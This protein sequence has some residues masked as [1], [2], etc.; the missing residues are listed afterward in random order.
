MANTNLDLNTVELVST[1]RAAPL[2][3]SPS[4]GDYNDS[5]TES[6]ADL[7]SL[8]GFINDI[9]IP[10]YN[11][12]ASNIQPSSIS[13]PLGLEGRF[14]YGDTTDTTPLF[15]DSLN[16]TSLTIP[17]SIRVVNGIVTTIQTIVT[18]LNVQV[19][20]IQTQLSSTN[21]NDIAQAL[22]NFAASLQILTA[23]TTG[24]TL[25]ISTVLANQGKTQNFRTV[26]TVITSGT[27]TE[28]V[29]SL[30]WPVSFVDN[31]YTVEIS[32][33]FTDSNTVTV[34]TTLH[35]YFIKQASG[36]GLNIHLLL[37][38]S[39]HAHTVVVHGK[40]THD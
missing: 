31:N 10:I 11:G 15:F 24:N 17:D 21:Q 4:S 12:L 33:E 16:N 28:T 19:T 23:Q 32:L 26:G 8:S 3:G 37:N 39:T 2:N 18:T 20:S 6:L 5:W 38:D 36:T 22:Q 9:I 34:G 7:A 25:S 35:Y 29:I 40:G 13:T 1:L 30:V 27:T 14:I